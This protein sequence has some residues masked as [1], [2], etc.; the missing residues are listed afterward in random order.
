MHSLRLLALAALWSAANYSTMANSA[1]E[2]EH[3]HDHIHFSITSVKNGDWSNP[4]TWSPARTPKQ[5]DRVLIGRGTNVRYDVKS[6]DVIR[7][8]Q[9]VGTLDFARERNTELNVGILKVQN[10]DHCSE[11]GF[12]CD[13]RGAQKTG[14]PGDLFPQQR[15]QLLIGTPDNPIPAKHTAKIRLH[16]IEGMDK[17]N[18]P[19]LVC[20]S[21]Q[22][23]IHGSPMNRTWVKLGAN[24][25][26]GAA[27]VTL[28]EEVTGW[29]IGDSVIVTGSIHSDSGQTFRG[30]YAKQKAQ[31]EERQIIKINGRTL[32][33]NK[34]LKNEHFGEGEFR[35]EVANLSR[36][37]VVESAEPDGVRGHTLYHRF[38]TGSLSYARFAH[39]G[40]EGVLG[41][42][43]IH[44]HLVRDS[45]RGSQVKGV[46]VV[47]SHNRWIT[48]HG[49]QYLV[50]RDCVGYQSVGHGF[51]LEDATEVYNLFD[52]NLGVQ[53]YNG[54]RLPGQVLP[55]DPNEGAAFWW[56]NGRNSFVRNV[57]CENDEYGFRYDCQGSRSFDIEMPILS[58][59]GE[60]ETVDVR[61]VGLFRFEANESH[62]EGLYG[63]AFAGNRETETK[64][65]GPDAEH[66]HV[67]R[68]LKIW[69]VHY[70]LRPQIPQML[71]EN[72]QIDHAVY[73]I[74]RPMF[75]NHVYRDISISHTNGEPFNRGLDD[76]S[77]QYGKITVDGLTFAGFYEGGR[78]PLIQMSDNNL[79]GDAESHF[80]N[81][82]VQHS[83]DTNQRSWFGRGG[84]SQVAQSSEKGVP[85]YL[86]DH[87]GAGR[88]ARILSRLAKTELAEGGKY[89]EQ[90]PVTGKDALMTEVANVPFPALLNPIDDLAPAS[91]I[92]SVRRDGDRFIVSGVSHD[93]GEIKAV[94]VNG[95]QADIIESSVGGGLADWRIELKAN[96]AKTFTVKAVDRA[97]NTEQHL[98]TVA[99]N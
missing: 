10:S 23:E 45:M 9:I 50:V 85:Y 16:Y 20:C 13:F 11:S 60:R 69:Q 37:V 64:R 28:A 7:L 4:K 12:A 52:R 96:D 48:V 54:K 65:I 26:P 44:F 80:R 61:N 95:Q 5:G 73:G 6:K 89:I 56:T 49:T 87:Y 99:V 91:I 88:H 86:H 72:V 31:T 1:E 33:L 59:T 38:S 63:M 66:P 39:L 92:T 81:V 46:S 14:E 75:D 22:M 25:Q 70:A 21:A 77:N 98:H 35:S 19:A 84:G 18:A 53:A 67:L 97:G 24:A 2:H 68:N 83:R 41:R 36:N 42:Y 93:N 3:V 78:M 34:P 90:A 62:T 79:S 27:E 71:M 58:Q 51:F 57:A 47:D 43:A 55:F 40:K 94:I 32:T 82:N 15:P 30:E 8:V 29:S 74:Y 76:Q 17:K